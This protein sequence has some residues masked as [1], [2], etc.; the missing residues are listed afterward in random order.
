MSCKT[1]LF[2]S[3]I[4]KYKGRLTAAL[5]CCP[6]F[7]FFL[8]LHS[9][10]ENY[11]QVCL[12]GST[13]VCNVFHLLV[14]ISFHILNGFALKKCYQADVSVCFWLRCGGFKRLFLFFVSVL[15]K[16]PFVFSSLLFHIVWMPRHTWMGNSVCSPVLWYFKHG[17]YKLLRYCLEEKS[18]DNMN[19]NWFFLDHKCSNCYV[20]MSRPDLYSSFYFF[21]LCTSLLFGSLWQV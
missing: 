20:Y 15:K 9:G 7:R 12:S 13:D 2:L 16:N 1:D 4:L 17:F 6:S 8:S 19:C 14:I 5:N 18:F 3:F 10:V 11:F 21:L